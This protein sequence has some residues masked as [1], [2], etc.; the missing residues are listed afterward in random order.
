[1]RSWSCWETSKEKREARRLSHP[2]RFFFLL[3]AAAVSLFLSCQSKSP[4]LNGNQMFL[5]GFPQCKSTV[6]FHRRLECLHRL[7]GSSARGPEYPLV[8]L[9]N[10]FFLR[11]FYASSIFLLCKGKIFLHLLFIPIFL[12]SAIIKMRAIFSR[13]RLFVLNTTCPS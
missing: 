11:S 10:G 13:H 5:Q 8:H 3:E 6:C 7:P 12:P 4:C 1:M 9:S 2:W